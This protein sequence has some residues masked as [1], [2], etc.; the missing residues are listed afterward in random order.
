MSA[1]YQGVGKRHTFTQVTVSMAG[2]DGAEGPAAAG[3]A[4]LLARQ[5]RLR[6]WSV[7]ID[8]GQLTIPAEKFTEY[9]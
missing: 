1:C 8:L 7:V 4:R 2:P 5:T 3:L 6:Q 9:W